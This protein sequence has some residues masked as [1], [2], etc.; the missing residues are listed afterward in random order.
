MV[1]DRERLMADLVALARSVS[2]VAERQGEGTDWALLS[3]T[4]DGLV[5]VHRV[6]LLRA[7]HRPAFEAWAR[8]V[9]N[10]N[11]DLRVSDDAE[12]M[13]YG[14]KMLWLAYLAG[15]SVNAAKCAPTTIATYPK[16]PGD[17]GTT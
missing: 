13:C 9:Y 1:D 15:T 2:A 4:A 5:S 6:A 12:Y 17:G 7:T 11:T 3:D 16:P 10:N 14:T 8:T